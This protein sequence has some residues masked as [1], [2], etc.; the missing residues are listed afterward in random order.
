M[1]PRAARVAMAVTADSVYLPPSVALFPPPL[2]IAKKPR[3]ATFRQR[4][5]QTVSRAPYAS[6]DIG[7]PL[8]D[9]IDEIAGNIWQPPPELDFEPSYLTWVNPRKT[10]ATWSVT[11]LPVSRIPSD[12]PLNIRKNRNSRSTASGSSGW[13][14]M[15]SPQDGNQGE[16]VSSLP[17]TAAIPWPSLDED[18]MNMTL[19]EFDAFT[20][21]ASNHQIPAQRVCKGTLHSTLYGAGDSLQTV[22][23]HTSRLRRFTTNVSHRFRRTAPGD[24]DTYMGSTPNT[25][26]ETSAMMP[27]GEMVAGNC[28]APSNGTPKKDAV[29]AYLTKHGH[30]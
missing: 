29:H 5:L 20:N 18:V 26:A 24:A 30:E 22:N 15:V 4:L 2:H 11:P 23:R 14:A 9:I 13:E 3:R 16:P 7:G 8:D 1:L 27:L 19:E 21:T 25:L 10:S 28:D 12:Q 6:F 17:D